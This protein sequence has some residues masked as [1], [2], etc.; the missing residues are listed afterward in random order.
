V[1]KLIYVIQLL[2]CLGW[3][4]FAFRYIPTGNILFYITYV[5]IVSLSIFLLGRR[6][7]K[8]FQ[9]TNFQLKKSQY[10]RTWQEQQRFN[11]EFD[12][13][14]KDALKNKN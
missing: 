8:L 13:E 3:T 6:I 11:R 9:W 2:L 1:R 5:A 12:K 4:L 10:F 14:I 7:L